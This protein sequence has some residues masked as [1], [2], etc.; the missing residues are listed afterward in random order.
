M[1]IA[2][3]H[4]Y[5]KINLMPKNKGFGLLEI[6]IATAIISGTIF[7]LSYVF[8]IS[9]KLAAE[10]SNKIRAIFLAE[11][12]LEALRALRD[13]SWTSNLSVLNTSTTYYLSF[14]T[15]TSIWS[16][17]TANP[18]FVDGLFARTVSIENVNRD[19]ATDNI[20]S[21]G[22][23]NDP[24]T[25]KFNVSVAWSERTGTTTIIVSTYL[26]DMFDN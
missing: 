18:G 2:S 17:G 10:S 16:I 7:S 4:N 12:G 3:V 8:L 26:T 6:V 24:D 1:S 14:A 25:K 21:S 9:N 23:T 11:E 13:R 5:A 19:P 20:V 22:G 15:T